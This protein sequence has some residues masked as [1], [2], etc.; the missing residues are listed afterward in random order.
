MLEKLIVFVEEYS[1]EA[2]LDIL[3]PSMLD[4]AEH[5]IIRFQCKDD[6]LKQL[7]SRLKGYSAW[8]PDTWSILVLVDRDDDD[9]M[10]L[11]QQLEQYAR[12]AGFLTR[13]CAR[14]GENFKV[15]NRI[16]IEELESWYFGDW[17][18]VKTAY[19]KVPKNIPGK[20]TYR[21]PDNIQGG[22]WEALERILKR[23]GL[24]C[25]GAAQSRVCKTGCPVYGYQ[26]KPLFEF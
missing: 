7:P 12:D 3:L 5:Q 22:T 6:L 23:A 9:C 2:A 11:K 20:A 8:M 14:A 4:G 1:M 15:T 21:D 16:V 13:S 25:R 17:A 26:S 19:P 18:A 24:F 10:I